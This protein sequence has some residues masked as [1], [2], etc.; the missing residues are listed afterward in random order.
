MTVSD[1]LSDERLRQDEFPVCR[2]KAY[3]AHA[4]VAPLDR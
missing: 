3:L 2:S 4:G 1:I